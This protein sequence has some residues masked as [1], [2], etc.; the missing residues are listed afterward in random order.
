L[1][2][3]HLVDHHSYLFVRFSKWNVNKNK[4]IDLTIKIHFINPFSLAMG[5]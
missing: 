1:V 2:N 4:N 3:L 5:L